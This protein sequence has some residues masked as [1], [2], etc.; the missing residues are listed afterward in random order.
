MAITQGIRCAE[1]PHIAAQ[2]VCAAQ[3]F[4]SQAFGYRKPPRC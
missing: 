2:Q 4:A 1:G 3:D